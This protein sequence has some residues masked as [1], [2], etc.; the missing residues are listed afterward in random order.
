MIPPLSR[1]PF[2]PHPQVMLS[3]SKFFVANK[4]ARAFLF[5]YLVC[6]HLLV[7]GAMY[8]ASHHC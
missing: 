5:G 1:T 3:F 2:T 7:S 8:T 6:L 4:H